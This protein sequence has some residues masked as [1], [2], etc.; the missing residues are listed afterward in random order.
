MKKL[1]TEEF[2]RRAKEVHGDRYIYDKTIYSNS[3]VDLSVMCS[4]HGEFEQT[5]SNHLSGKGCSKCAKNIF[6]EDTFVDRAREIHGDRYD[7]SKS[8]YVNT[9]TK[10]EVNC[11]IHGS[12]LQTPTLHLQ[13]CGC[14]KCNGSPKINNDIFIERVRKVHGDKYDYSLVDYKNAHTKVK[15]LCSDHG[16]FEQTPNN[17]YRGKGCFVCGKE[18]FGIGINERDHFIPYIKALLPN[19]KI[20]TQ[21][22]IPHETGNYFVDAYLPQENIVIEYDE[23]F[24]HK[25]KSSDKQRQSYIESKLN[26]EFIRVDDK[27]FMEN[28]SY[29]DTLLGVSKRQHIEE[30]FE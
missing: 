3:H 22:P 9:K 13:G 21:Y 15:I 30:L 17:H 5:P 6:G 4:V 25:Q 10:L 24:H 23:L 26:C 28:H 19:T 27:L 16:E 7:Y 20:E 1:T 18:T 2:I 12:F 14:P 8:V 11:T 29:L